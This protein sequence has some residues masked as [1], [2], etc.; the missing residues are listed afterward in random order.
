MSKWP[1]YIPPLTPEQRHIANDFMKRWHEHIPGKYQ[2]LERFNH[3][4]PMKHG[5]AFVSTLEI[6]AGI[7][8][9]LDYESDQLSQ[10]QKC[11]YV[12]VEMLD[13]M[14]DVI[15]ARHPEVYVLVGDCQQRLPLYQERFDRIMAIHVLEH[16]PNLPECI[17]EM[18]RVIKPTGTFYVVIPC[19]GGVLYRMARDVSSRRMFEK[20][21]GQS[22]DWFIE[23]E[24]INK[25][26]EIMEELDPYFT[27]QDCT[28]FPF[29]VQSVDLNLC[30]GLKLKPL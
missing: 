23:R 2:M 7:G 28:F 26:K 12:A 25:P 13:G 6:G 27:V 18:R 5:D 8:G 1:K 15:K 3:G 24:H 17:K 9:Q 4:Y 21:Y 30:I 19:E 29:R 11:N 20:L 22:Y 16:L 10:V 14:A